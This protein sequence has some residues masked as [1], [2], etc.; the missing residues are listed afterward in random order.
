MRDDV[1]QCSFKLEEL[2]ILKD[3]K[4]LTLKVIQCFL[5]CRK[6]VED[7]TMVFKKVMGII[8]SEALK[9]NYGFLNV[10]V[11]SKVQSICNGFENCQI[12]ISN[13]IDEDVKTKYVS[14]KINFSICEVNF[15]PYM[16]SLIETKRSVIAT[17][18]P[19][20][21]IFISTL[22]MIGLEECRKPLKKR[23]V[24]N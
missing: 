5:R 21:Q 6:S 7:N 23:K 20:P 16:A 15:R 22:D 14:S 12:A 4:L 19:T 10:E 13:F 8:C 17:P 3:R 9:P 1:Y 24:I 11:L 2:M 18:T